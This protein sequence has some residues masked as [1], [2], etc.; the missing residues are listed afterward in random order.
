MSK[1]LTVVAIGFFC[2]VGAGQVQAQAQAQSQKMTP[3]QDKT[4]LCEK[5]AGDKKGDVRKAFVR[6][7]LAAKSEPQQNKV[8][9]CDH[10]SR[11]EDL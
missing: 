8:A 6:T 2:S 3:Q 10:E 11:A 5:A 9:S 7:C 4:A 1:F